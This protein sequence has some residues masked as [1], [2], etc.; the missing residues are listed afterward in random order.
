[1][2]DKIIKVYVD[3]QLVLT[4]EFEGFY[5][6]EEYEQALHDLSAFCKTLLYTKD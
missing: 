3:G 2:A 4:K 6:G 5:M 1:M